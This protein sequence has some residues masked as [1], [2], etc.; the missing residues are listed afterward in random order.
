MQE[1]LKTVGTWN[2]ILKTF[3]F[4]LKKVLDLNRVYFR[5]VSGRFHGEKKQNGWNTKIE[6]VEN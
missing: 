3:N 6:F 1:I 2:K 4:P 5:F